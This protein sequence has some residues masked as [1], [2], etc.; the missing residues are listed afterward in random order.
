MKHHFLVSP[1]ET[2]LCFLI[3]HHLQQQISPLK[4]NWLKRSPSQD[5]LGSFRLFD[6]TIRTNN[7]KTETAA[8]LMNHLFLL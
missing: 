4:T 2:T 7:V 8:R 3:K 6:M 1:T 5:L